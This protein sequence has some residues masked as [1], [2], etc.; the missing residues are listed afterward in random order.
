M[1]DIF[2]YSKSYLDEDLIPYVADARDFYAKDYQLMRSRSK[3]Y[4]IN[5][6]LFFTAL[7]KAYHGQSYEDIARNME[8]SESHVRNQI[9]ATQNKVRLYIKIKAL[10]RC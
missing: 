9:L 7:A 2:I 10:G 6:L 5:S 3:I 8:L 4:Y 1:R